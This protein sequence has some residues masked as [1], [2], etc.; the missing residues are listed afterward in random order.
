[1]TD[2]D[3]VTV[4][5]PRDLADQIDRLR[6]KQPLGYTSRAELVKEAVRTYLAALEQ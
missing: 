4:K 3:W 1:M 5:L 6:K 2:S